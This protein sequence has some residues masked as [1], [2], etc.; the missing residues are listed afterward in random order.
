MEI[1]IRDI[2]KRFKIDSQ[3]IVPA[4]A[5]GAINLVELVNRIV[6]V[7]PNQKKFSIVREAK[8]ENVSEEASKNAEKGIIDHI[9]EVVGA[10]VEVIAEAV[11]KVIAEKIRSWWPW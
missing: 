9:K 6:E 11:I 3:D 1:K 8:H 2:S 4:S 7:L 10:V 5:S